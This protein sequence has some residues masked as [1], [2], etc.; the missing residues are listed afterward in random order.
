MVK[1]GMNCMKYLLLLFNLLFVVFGIVLIVVGIIVKVK[2]VTVFGDTTYASMPIIIFLTGLLTFLLAFLGCCGA[3]K[4]SIFKLSLFGIL[5]LVLLICQIAGIAIAFANR[6]TME[7]IIKDNMKNTLKHQKKDAISSWNYIQGNFYCCGVD[8]PKD[9]L[10]D[11]LDIPKSCCKPGED[12]CKE[13]KAF[14]DG[15]YDH[16]VSF[17]FSNMKIFGGVGGIIAAVELVSIIFTFCLVSYIRKDKQGP[18][19]GF[20]DS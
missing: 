3:K 19:M 6:R 8:G 7:S 16:L 14:K 11:K 20:M 17:I 4:E 15:C 18:Q 13:D 2:E 9:Y 10:D 1:V 5:L 12:D